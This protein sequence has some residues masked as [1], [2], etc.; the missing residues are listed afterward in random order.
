MAATMAFAS[1]P[2]NR[3]TG[4]LPFGFSPW[5]PVHDAAPGGASAAQAGVMPAQTN[6][7]MKA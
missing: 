6:M 3:G 2:A 7:T 1:C 4:V 5:H